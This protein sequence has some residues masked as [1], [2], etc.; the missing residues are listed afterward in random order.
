[1]ERLRQSS[2]PSMEVDGAELEAAL[3]DLDWVTLEFNM[4]ALE[5]RYATYRARCARLLG[6]TPWLTRA[7]ILV[8]RVG[9]DVVQ[10]VSRGTTWHPREVWVLLGFVALVAS[11]RAGAKCVELR[12]G[13]GSRDRWTRHALALAVAHAAQIFLAYFLRFGDAWSRPYYLG[14]DVA[15]DGGLFAL[16]FGLKL[17]GV[18]LALSLDVVA[19][20]ACLLSDAHAR[21]FPLLTGLVLLVAFSCVARA[22]ERQ[23]RVAFAQAV[24]V[25]AKQS[26]DMR[27]ISNPFSANNLAAWLFPAPGDGGGAGVAM[28]EVKVDEELAESRSPKHGFQ[29]PQKALISSLTRRSRHA[30]EEKAHADDDLREHRAAATRKRFATLQSWQIDF[31]RLRVVAKIGAGA[32]GQVYEGEFLGA[33]VA[34]KQLFSSFIDPSDLDEFSREVTLLHKLKHPHVLTFYGISRRDVY[35]FIVTEHCPYALDALL[36][37]EAPAARRGTGRAARPPRLSVNDRSLILF[38]VALALTYLHAERVLHHDL[39]PGNILLDKD[40]GA[41][42]S[43][44]GLSQLVDD[45]GGD[46]GQ[47]RKRSAPRRMSAGA[48]ACYAA[49]EML[50]VG[51]GVLGGGESPRVC[52]FEAMSRLDVFA[53]GIVTAATFSQNGDPY[54]HYVTPGTL[55]DREKAIADAVKAGEL[56]PQVPAAL[57]DRVRAT[58]E[59]CWAQDPER[60]PTFADVAAR[61]RTVCVGQGTLAVGESTKLPLGPDARDPSGGD[62]ASLL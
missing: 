10:G 25:D 18:L 59:A 52:G 15:V 13:D 36:R 45:D 39:K 28:P 58:M 29:S 27:G 20:L 53:F 56:R 23:G 32:A 16:C 33:R 42:V 43:D 9:A 11:L 24:R 31:E 7:G 5:E 37:G 47:R 4:A 41:K 49:P 55:A 14:L 50:G 62:D 46:D 8:V 40:L 51:G 2:A 30:E 35:C 17:K 34:I 1:M 60:R 22:T 26:T 6:A 21:V 38:Q 3:T 57:P 61:L 44:F 48:T 54:H 19:L 12:D